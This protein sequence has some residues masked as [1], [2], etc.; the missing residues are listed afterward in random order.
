M[1]RRAHVWLGT[2]GFALCGMMGSKEAAAAGGFDAFAAS[3]SQGSVLS[4]QVSGP[5]V[6]RS[7]AGSSDQSSK[8]SSDNSSKS[9]DDS[10]AESSGSSD[11]SRDDNRPRRPRKLIVPQQVRDE[12]ALQLGSPAGQPPSALLRSTLQ[13]FR[14]QLAYENRGRPVEISDQQALALL[15]QRAEGVAANEPRSVHA[16]PVRG[17]QASRAESRV[18]R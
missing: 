11:S 10:S 8:H 15:L 12:A 14:L 3:S 6:S 16:Q 2:A 5:D 1:K 13:A 7:S 18:Q 4:S 9:S 17:T